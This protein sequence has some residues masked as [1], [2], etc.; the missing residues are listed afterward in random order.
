[1][2]PFMSSYKLSAGVLLGD[3]GES[4]VEAV[5]LGNTI[6]GDELRDWRIAL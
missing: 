6:L 1:M 5:E 2:I 4:N 3:R